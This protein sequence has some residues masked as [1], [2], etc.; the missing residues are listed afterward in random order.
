MALRILHIAVEN[1]CGI[2][3]DLVGAHRSHGHVSNLITYIPSVRGYEDDLCLRYAL[4]GS[5]LLEGLK[6]TLK[7]GTWIREIEYGSMEEGIPPVTDPASFLERNFLRFR[8]ILWE[9][10]ARKAIDRWGLL[11]YDIYHLEGGLGFLRSGEIVKELKARGKR[12][13]TMYYGS[14]LRL[15]GVHPV[16]EEAS[17][18]D[19]T[20]EFDHLKLYPKLKFLF[21]PTDI[22][23]FPAADPGRKKGPLRIGHSPTRRELKGTHSVIKAVDEVSR[24]YD[25][26]LV[27]IEGMSYKEAVRLKSSCQIFIDQVGNTGGT[28]YGVS[29]VESLAMGIPTVTDFAPDLEEFIPDHPFVLANPD[30]L[31]EMIVPLLEDHHLRIAKGEEGRRWAVK[32]H[33]SERV[34]ERIYEFYREMNWIVG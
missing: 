31:A 24:N 20:I 27:L 14:D 22:S 2:P 33:H 13:V 17:D 6:K 1:F 23:R 12:I 4:V 8:D 5:P 11:E 32:N 34:A 16:I 10:K 30:N 9:R 7:V 3:L 15:R 18:L 28:G 29:S 21:L 19:L 26:E 25:V